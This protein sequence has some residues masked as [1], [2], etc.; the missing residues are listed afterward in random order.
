MKKCICK[1]PCGSPN[2]SFSIDEICEYKEIDLLS[3]EKRQEIVVYNKEGRYVY[4]WKN[5]FKIFFY[6]EIEYR[7]LKLDKLNI[8]WK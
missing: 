2:T 5:D 1:V 4:F 3:A 6:T 7:K 8:R